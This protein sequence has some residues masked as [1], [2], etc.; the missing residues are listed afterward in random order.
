MRPS[1]R[2]KY[3]A[4]P[5]DHPASGQTNGHERSDSRYTDY[6]A[7]PREGWSDRES[8][9][10][11]PLLAELAP[12]APFPIDALPALLCDTTLAIAE[13]AQ[14]GIELA[15]QSVLATAALAVRGQYPRPTNN[16]HLA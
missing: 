2:T 10:P 11:L 6:G 9:G 8:D 12:P 4:D 14:V 5:E 15:A 16:C 7:D 13:K 1:Q 3:G